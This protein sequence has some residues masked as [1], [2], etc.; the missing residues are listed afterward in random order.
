MMRRTEY[1]V[2][3]VFVAL[4]DD[5]DDDDDAPIDLRQTGR[6]PTSSALNDLAW[7]S[8]RPAASRDDGQPIPAAAWFGLDTVI[9]DPTQRPTVDIWRRP[10]MDP[11]FV[12]T[13]VPRDRH[14]R[15]PRLACGS[16]GPCTLSGST[17]RRALL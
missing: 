8:A 14:T 13:W 2:Y 5:D 4:D 9:F 11:G 3:L 10:G 15:R 6:Y 7:V 17:W 1:L 12:G 16:G